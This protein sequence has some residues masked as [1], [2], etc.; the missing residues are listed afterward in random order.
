DS[1]TPTTGIPGA[2]YDLYVQGSPPPSGVPGVAPGDVAPEPGDTW[3]ARGTTASDGRLSFVVPAGYAWC[4]REVTAP[5]D[6]QLDQALRCSGAITADSSPTESTIAVA[7]T[8][9]TVHLTAYK[10]NS[11]DPRTVIPGASYELLA[12]E[13]LPPGAPTT[14]PAG[15]S[16]PAGDAFW[17]EGTTD[18]NGVL[19]FAVPAGFSW[20]LHEVR[21]PDAYRPDPAF[22]CTATLTTDSK[23]AAATLAVPELPISRNLAFTGFPALWLGGG[24]LALTAVGGGAVAIDL[25]RRRRVRRAGR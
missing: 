14:V 5:I 3:Y 9:A 7:E 4:V 25:A 18:H 11:A 16:V 24:G 23:A 1:L 19:A 10:F 21:A 2:T 8:R 22:H 17:A 12:N 20:C 13:S 6:Y 15:A